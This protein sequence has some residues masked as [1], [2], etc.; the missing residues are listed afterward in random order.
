MP[1]VHETEKVLSVFLPLD[2]FR[3]FSKDID[4]CDSSETLAVKFLNYFEKPLW[5]LPDFRIIA[6][7]LTQTEFTKLFNHL[8]KQN[9]LTPYQIYLLTLGFPEVSGVIKRSLS[10]NS[11]K[12][13]LALKK[14]AGKMN[15]GK[16]DIIGGIYSI[17]ESIFFILKKADDLEYSLF[18]KKLQRLTF[19]A[20]NLI[21]LQRKEFRVHISEIIEDDLLLPVLSSIDD[22]ILGMAFSMDAGDSFLL[23]KSGLS[24]RKQMN[25]IN[26]MNNEFSFIDVLSARQAIL[27]QYR[28]LKIRKSGAEPERMEY[29]LSCLHSAEDYQNLLLSVGW[30][31]LSTA[32]KG[33]HPSLVDKLLSFLPPGARILIEDVLSGTLN[34]NIIHDEGQMRKAKKTCVE[35]I[36]ELFGD[37]TIAFQC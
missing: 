8:Q 23:A 36:L 7:S 20:R 27:K 13:V 25:I 29:L 9:L 6:N 34:P 37:G 14:N 18:I 21:I 4:I 5:M 26:C 22:L 31:Q 35:A 3:L 10:K 15:L 12:D 32:M 2:F 28:S 33:L 1:G 17:E 24:E 19:F 30:F 16:R 11:I